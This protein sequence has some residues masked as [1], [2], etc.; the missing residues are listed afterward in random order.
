MTSEKFGESNLCT[1]CIGGKKFTKWIRKNGHRGKCNFDPSHGRSRKVVGLEEFAVE[2]GRHFQENYCFGECNWD[3]EQNGEPYKDIL[4]N[5]LECDDTIVD[6][7]SEHLPDSS[8]YDGDEPFYDDCRNY[9]PIADVNKR[10]QAEEQERW[11]EERYTYQWGK[12]CEEV[13]YKN[14]FFKV[15]EKLDSLFGKPEEYEKGK[16]RPLYS[17]DVGVRIYRGR[18]MDDDFTEE[19]LNNNRAKELGAPPKNKTKAG[20]MNVEFIPA[21]YATFCE[22]TAIAEIRPSIGDTVAV[23]EFILKKSIKVFDFT[24]FS[25]VPHEDKND[26]FRHTRYDFIKQMRGEI[27]KPVSPFEKQREYIPT[28]MVAEY[29]REYFECDAVIFESSLSKDEAKDNRNI[30][31]LNKDVDFVGEE[32]NGILSYSR[33]NIYQISNV[34]YAFYR[35][36]F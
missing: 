2:V 24:A 35:M 10:E 7:L 6:A 28:Q 5:D 31:I 26:C 36:P 13:Q 25:N 14:R 33:H 19:T 34:T 18:Q 22:D 4:I 29:L 32:E 27:G 1:A 8:P 23:G 3:Y 12:F 17:L 16:I 21:F 30:V 9:E 15:K 11:Y 20:R